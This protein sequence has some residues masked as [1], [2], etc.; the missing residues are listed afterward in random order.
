M[1]YTAKVY[2]V[3]E[4]DVAYTLKYDTIGKDVNIGDSFSLSF[5][6]FDYN[7]KHYYVKYAINNGTVYKRGVNTIDCKSMM[8][9]DNEAYMNW[10]VFCTEDE[11]EITGDSIVST[12]DIASEIFLTIDGSTLS[13]QGSEYINSI[14]IM[15]GCVSDSFASY[16]STYSPTIN[17]DMFSCEFTDA[18]ISKAYAN[19]NYTLINAWMVIDGHDYNPIPIGR[20]VVKENPT[21]NGETVSFTGNGLM[22]EY[23][24][25]S[26]ISISSLNEYHKADLEK[27][28]VDTGK[29]DFIYTGDDLYFWEYL[30]Q[31]FLR[32]T[33]C[34]LYID[35]W[36]DV[37]YNMGVYG[38]EQLMIPMVSNASYDDENGYDISWETRITWR[39]LLSGIA[40]ILRANVIEK[41]GAFYIKQLPQLQTSGTYRPIFD[42][43]S[44]DSNAIF[45]NNLMCPNNISVKANNW[46][47]YKPNNTVVGFGYYEGESTVVLNNE[48]SEVSN[49]ENYPV[50][51]ESPWILYE[52]L[53]RHDL[54]NTDCY[55]W[56][57]YT[58][59]RYWRDGLRFLNNAFVYHKASIETMYWHPFMSVGEMLTFEDHDGVKKY[60]LV[61]EMTL[62]YNGTVYAEITSPCEVQETNTSSVGGGGSTSYNS[63]T[64]AQASGMA[65]GT[66]LGA[67][68]KDGV[69]TN[70][71]IA[72]STITGSKIAESTI[73]NSNIKDST[74]TGSKFEDGTIENSKIKDSTLTG[75]KIADATIGFEKVNTSFIKDLT[76]DKAYIDNLTARIGDFGFITAYSADLKYATITSLQAVDGKIDTLTAKAI[77]TDNLEAEVATLGYLSAESADVKFATIESLTAVDGK[78]DTLSSKAITTENLSAKVADLGYLSAESAE[79]G[80]AKIDFANVKGQV[81]GSSLIKDGAVTN[82]KVANLSANKIT[83]GTIDA[84][85]ITVTNLNADNITVGTINGQRIGNGSLSLDK[86]AEEVP[87]KEYLDN[88]E[89]N[90]QGQIDGAI[91]TFTKSEIPTLNNEPANAWVDNETRKK[92]IGDVCYVLNPTSSADGYCY[93]FANTGT[94]ESPSYEWVLI[95]D[96]DVTKALQ[97]IININKE[98]TGIKKF[99]TD[100]S[101]WKI[102]T[103]KELSSLKLRTTTLETDMGSKVESSVFNEVKQ[104]V[105]ENSSNITSLSTTV[106]KKADGS[107]VE[108]L[109]N[110]VNEVKQ[111]ADSNSLSISGMQTEI[112]KKADGSTVTELSTRTSKLEQNLDGFKTEVS[113]TYTTKEE[114]ESVDNKLTTNLLKP[115]LETVTQ[116]GVTFT[117]NGDGTYTLNGT[118][119][120]YTSPTFATLHLKNGKYKLLGIGIAAFQRDISGNWHQT[121]NDGDVIEI[122]DE[123]PVLEIVYVV[124]EGTHLDNVLIKPM[125]TTNLNATYD[126]FVP[127]TGSTGSLNGDLATNHKLTETVKTIA[128]QT[129]D[130]FSWLVKSGTSATNFELTDRT[131]NLV[132]NHINLNGLVTFSGLN[133]DAQNKINSAENAVN[134]L[135]IGGRNLISNIASNWQQGHWSDIDGNYIN[136]NGRICTKIGLKVIPGETYAINIYL[137]GVT[138]K[139]LLFRTYGSDGS[140]IGSVIGITNSIYTVPSNVYELRFA[141]YENVTL[142]D[143]TNGDVRVKVE[144]GNKAT[145]WS[146]APE[147][148]S[149]ENI[150]TTNTTTIDGGK[151]TTGSIKAEKI[152]TGT[153]TAKQISSGAITT[154]KLAANAV[155]AEKINV[156]DLFAQDITATGTI[157]GATLKGAHVESTSG[158]IGGFDIGEDSISLSGTGVDSTFY[159]GLTNK[160]LNGDVFGSLT[161]YWKM[162]GAGTAYGGYVQISHGKLEAGTISGATPIYTPSFKADGDSITL[163]NIAS[164]EIKNKELIGIFDGTTPTI[165]TRTLT[166]NAMSLAGNYDGETT[167]TIENVSEYEVLAVIP[168]TSAATDVCW[169]NC[170]FD[171]SNVVHA[172]LKNTASSEKNNFKPTVEVLYR[173]I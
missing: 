80:Y 83:S 18:L 82:E 101:S 12:E 125:L 9:S 74:I 124:R 155:T 62:H 152:Y 86:L 159:T 32:V 96:S 55:P 105:D 38:L 61:G 142:D 106:S 56:F 110:T 1:S 113:K 133:S 132:A 169:I 164:L 19:G 95:K 76:A 81:V 57:G 66:I 148:I 46:Y 25:I 16:G 163:G 75:A 50:T 154:D 23:M 172:R 165:V 144:K 43:S 137:N 117:N 123:Y 26:E 60:V 143:L 31:D 118:A 161:S 121:F 100:I 116:N 54:G 168:R 129:A 7:G 153:I 4:S 73:E 48:N 70:S 17:C 136:Y 15:Q 122:V 171:S 111:T 53:D 102:D 47:F 160:T 79:I 119:S 89:K 27:K 30:P 115:T 13:T 20:F 52:M 114:L 41:N 145:D 107:T 131:A 22:S 65:M 93:R 28:Y 104:T 103:D 170:Y 109:T 92:H 167:G 94:E 68:F 39:D 72:D 147:D 108:T 162:S 44:Y 140:F 141:L 2:Y 87:T 51:I 8:I 149:V 42:R 120:A 24:D 11:S 139:Y 126:D 71:K 40:I 10:F 67:I 33:G 128:E 91:E 36:N 85:K 134:N 97:D 127:Y 69:I 78:I 37:L 35:N 151:I 157:T 99:D 64:T 156:K 90:L 98:I 34:P 150:Y 49:V 112:G 59:S 45:G 138:D 6:D 21:Y 173:L 135:E 166:L 63:G 130:K 5:L 88:V 77:T 58:G 14:D 3:L 146:P 158:S 84:S 29:M